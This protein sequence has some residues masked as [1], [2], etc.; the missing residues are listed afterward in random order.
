M[1]DDSSEVPLTALDWWFMEFLGDFAEIKARISVTAYRF[2]AGFAK[3][4]AFH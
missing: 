2:A 1:T 4:R 3:E